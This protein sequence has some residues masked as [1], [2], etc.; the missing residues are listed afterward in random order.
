MP[1]P[2]DKGHLRAPNFHKKHLLRGQAAAIPFRIHKNAPACGQKPTPGT[3]LP[4]WA[5]SA[6]TGG[7]Y[8]L[9]AS[10]KMPPPVDKSPLPAPNFHKKHLLRGQAATISFRRRNR[11]CCRRHNRRCVYLSGRGNQ[12]LPRLASEPS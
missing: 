7:C 10:T 11:G 8:F 6:W 9:S 2:V 4:R 3:G 5:P 1:P 12:G